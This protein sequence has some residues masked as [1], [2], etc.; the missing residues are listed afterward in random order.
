MADGWRMAD[1]VEKAHVS[2]VCRLSLALHQCGQPRPRRCWAHRPLSLMAAE[3]YWTLPP[4]IWLRNKDLGGGQV[5]DQTTHLTDL[6]NVFGGPVISLSANYTLNTY[7]DAEFHNWDGY[8]LTCKHAGGAVSSLHCTYALFPQI[9]DFAPPRVDLCC[10]RSVPAPDAV[11][12]DGCDAPRH[13]TNTPIRASS[14]LTSIRPSSPPLTPAIA[15]L[16]TP[17]C[18]RHC[19]A[20]R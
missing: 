15:P 3:W 16:C 4:I 17:P 5:V 2:I 12:A 9:A 7:A 10:P 19:A 1:A 18:L 20:W 11:G 14:T 8:A 6:F 13:E